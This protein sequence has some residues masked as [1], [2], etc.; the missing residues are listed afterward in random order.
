LQDWSLEITAEGVTAVSFGGGL[1]GEFPRE[2]F[3]VGGAVAGAL[4]LLTGA[5]PTIQRGLVPLLSLDMLIVLAT[6][7]APLPG[8]KPITGGITR[9]TATRGRRSL[10]R[11]VVK[12]S[13]DDPPALQGAMKPAAAVAK[14]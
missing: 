1:T 12:K 2:R 10:A 9:P 4:R 3:L 13:S 7:A 11:V 6:W 8:A 14:L 5:W